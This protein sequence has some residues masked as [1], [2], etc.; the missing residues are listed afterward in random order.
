MPA[1]RP[2]SWKLPA[3]RRPTCPP[4]RGARRRTARRRIHGTYCEASVV[5]SL[6]HGR[7]LVSRIRDS[8]SGI[9][10]TL[11]YAVNDRAR[12]WVFI[13]GRTFVIETEDRDASQGGRA[14]DTQLALSA[15]MPATVI[16][17]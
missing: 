5:E 9:W 2:R 1:S 4:T 3:S 8:G 6:G 14:T 12:T 15:P 17:V 13:D 7:Y 16:A 10:K 11:A